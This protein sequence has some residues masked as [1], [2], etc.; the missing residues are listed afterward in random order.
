MTTIRT[1]RE[2]ECEIADGVRALTA[3]AS[4]AEGDAIQ[5]MIRA[6]LGAGDLLL[7]VR[8]LRPVSALAARDDLRRLPGRARA[9]GSEPVT[10]YRTTYHR[11]G[12]VTI[13]DC[14]S[15]TWLRR[16]RHLGDALL[17]TL[18]PDERA[19]VIRH[20]AVRS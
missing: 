17:S 15:Q 8:G 11:D 18:T 7:A 5:A 6:L 12:T 4:I 16:A 14:Y 3:A 20:T 13:W 10:R 2:I 19:R 1:I 9:P